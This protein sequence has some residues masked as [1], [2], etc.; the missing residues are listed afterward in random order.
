MCI[1]A[2]LEELRGH[3]VVP[4]ML[5]KS[6]NRILQNFHCKNRLYNISHQPKILPTCI[7]FIIEK[8]KFFEALISISLKKCLDSFTYFFLFDNKDEQHIY[9]EGNV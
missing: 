2:K 1:K 9:D 8:I 7:Q 3:K 5:D 6:T 4:E